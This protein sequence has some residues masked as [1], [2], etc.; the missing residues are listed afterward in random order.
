VHVPSQ[1]CARRSVPG[2]VHSSMSA[3][4]GKG[5]SCAAMNYPFNAMNVMWNPRDNETLG[6]LVLRS[7]LIYSFIR[8]T[9]VTSNS[10]VRCIV[11]SDYFTLSKLRQEWDKVLYILRSYIVYLL[12][13]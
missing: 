2:S 10:I 11:D 8:R 13:I 12:V 6:I 3:K 7:K 4:P 9:D 1:R 5:D